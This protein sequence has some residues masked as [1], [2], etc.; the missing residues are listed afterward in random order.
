M[1]L[2]WLLKPRIL[3]RAKAFNHGQFYCLLEEGEIHRGQPYHAGVRWSS[4][5]SVARRFYDLHDEIQLFMDQEGKDVFELQENK[6]LQDL[7][8]MLD[9]TGHLNWLDR[10]MQRRKKVLTEFYDSIRAFEIILQLWGK[11]LSTFSHGEISPRHGWVS[12]C[13]CH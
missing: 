12:W 3:I 7:A 11:Q 9:V 2:I 6:W 13:Y 1:F 8:F 5:G 10:K 4:R